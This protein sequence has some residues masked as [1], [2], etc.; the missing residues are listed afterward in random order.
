MNIVVFLE[1]KCSKN[2]KCYALC[3]FGA[4]GPYLYCCA[5]KSAVQTL[6]ESLQSDS[7]YAYFLT[8]DI[9]SPISVYRAKVFKVWGPRGGSRSARC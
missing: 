7:F 3:M 1:Y 4:Q 9:P 2:S 6:F 8:P 5:R